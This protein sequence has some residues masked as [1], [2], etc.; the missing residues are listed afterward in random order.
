MLRAPSKQALDH[1]ACALREAVAFVP[2][3]PSV[4]GRLACL[5]G[6]YD[7]RVDGDVRGDVLCPQAH[8]VFRNIIGLVHADRDA[9]LWRGVLPQHLLRC[10]TFRRAAGLR[11]QPRDGQAVPVF[12][13]G[14]SH[15]AEVALLP[16]T[17]AVEAAVGIGRAVMRVVLACRAVPWKFAP[18]PSVSLFRLKLLWPAHASISVPSTEK[19]SSDNSG[20]TS[21]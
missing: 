10:R 5:S 9:G 20:V 11:D 21:W 18:S 2:C 12:P 19:C 1:V 13:R 3:G 7:I 14:V 17:L 15:V 6:L 16:L 4:D 8:H